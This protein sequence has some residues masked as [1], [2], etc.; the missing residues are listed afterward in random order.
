LPSQDI[1]ED[2]SI[3]A[4]VREAIPVAVSTLQPLQMDERSR[5]RFQPQFTA[6]A[7]GLQLPDARLSRLS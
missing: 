5:A 4:S 2:R 3:P 7:H 6:S 1:I